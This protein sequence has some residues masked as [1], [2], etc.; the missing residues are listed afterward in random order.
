MAC[1]KCHIETQSEFCD[2]CQ[3]LSEDGHPEMPLDCGNCGAPLAKRVEGD[4]LCRVCSALLQT[5][6]ESRWLFRMHVEW[7]QENIQMARK[8]AE[9]M[10]TGGPAMLS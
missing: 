10:G 1:K 7:E 2:V 3:H 6:R 8:K 4:V 5:V 9:L